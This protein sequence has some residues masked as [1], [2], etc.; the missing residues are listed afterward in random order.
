[1]AIAVVAGILVLREQ[2]LSNAPSGPPAPTV[3]AALHT[4]WTLAPGYYESL[5]F[6][7]RVAATVT[8]GLFAS[9]GMAVYL[10]NATEYAAFNTTG[11]TSPNAYASGNV[12][13]VRI[14]VGLPAGPWDLVVSDP[15]LVTT[16]SVTVTTAVLATAS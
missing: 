6:E 2:E 10:F 16:T 7:L 13:S 5:S 8:G 3:L 14:Y 12:T 4:N 11:T 15:S 1:M 9:H